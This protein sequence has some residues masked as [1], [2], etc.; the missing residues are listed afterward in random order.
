MGPKKDNDSLNKQS[1]G[2]QEWI[3]PLYIDSYEKIVSGDERPPG[4]N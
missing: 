2:V 1:Y 4:T 3:N